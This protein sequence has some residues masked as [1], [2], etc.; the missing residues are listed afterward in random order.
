[1]LHIATDGQ[2]VLVNFFNQSKN[3]LCTITSLAFNFEIGFASQILVKPSKKSKF[4]ECFKT[5]LKQCP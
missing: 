3:L 4:L 5:G 1:M 2:I